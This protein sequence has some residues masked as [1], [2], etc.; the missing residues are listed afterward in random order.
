[1]SEPV[2]TG[3]VSGVALAKFFS[4]SVLAS[5]L[6]VAIGFMFMWPKTLKEA[7]IRIVCTVLASTF[8]GP[9]MVM[10]L[11]AWWPTLF[12]SAK[13]V[14][15]QAGAPAMFGLLFLAAP[16]MVLAGLPAWWVMG[17]VV[18]WLDNRRTKDIGELVGDV[19]QL[20]HPKETP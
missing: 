6:A 2:T 15:Q 5:A 10:A 3:A 7:F 13:T 8:F 14:A 17:A 1:M 20:I 4:G 12:E 19:R 9:L 18:R 16:I 11:H